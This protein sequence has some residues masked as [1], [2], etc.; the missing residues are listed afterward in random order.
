MG[1]RSWG[2]PWGSPKGPEMRAGSACRG[3]VQCL[4]LGSIPQP[5]STSH[6][7]SVQCQHMELK[8]GQ[9]VRSGS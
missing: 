2:E 1:K 3:C 6:F 5:C 7:S 9:M 4:V 8:M